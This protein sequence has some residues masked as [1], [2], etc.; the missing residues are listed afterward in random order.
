MEQPVQ[1]PPV[2]RLYMRPVVGRKGKSDH[3]ADD[4]VPRQKPSKRR[5]GKRQR[6]EGGDYLIE[7]TTFHVR[8]R[9]PRGRQ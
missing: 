9:W 4:E 2:E 1:S 6:S 3:P 8:P 5:H 7:L